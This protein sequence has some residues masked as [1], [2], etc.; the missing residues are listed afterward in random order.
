MGMGGQPVQHRGRLPRGTT[1]ARG[2]AG[3]FPRPS[4]VGP[5]QYAAQMLVLPQLHSPY[6]YWFENIIQVVKTGGGK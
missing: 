5:G 4:R 1:P 6:F 3:A 2:P